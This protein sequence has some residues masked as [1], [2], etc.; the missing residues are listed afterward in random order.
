MRQIL[1]ICTTLKPNIRNHFTGNREKLGRDRWFLIHRNLKFMP[2][3]VTTL[4][5]ENFSSYW[6]SSYLL[7]QMNF[8][9]L[10]IVATP[11]IITFQENFIK[12]GY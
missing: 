12:M 8:F 2:S 3:H 1:T 6:I 11:I 4:L 9:E 5:R 10:L 7:L